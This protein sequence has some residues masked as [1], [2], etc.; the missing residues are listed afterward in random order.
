MTKIIIEIGR[1]TM[2][3]IAAM[4]NAVTKNDDLTFVVKAHQLKSY[5]LTKGTPVRL[6]NEAGAFYLSVNDGSYL[7]PVGRWGSSE[8]LHDICAERGDAKSCFT[9]ASRSERSREIRLSAIAELK[10][11]GLAPNKR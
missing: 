9:S 2:I 6:L 7:M 3:E 10:N 4:I 8:E 5:E 1:H 11:R